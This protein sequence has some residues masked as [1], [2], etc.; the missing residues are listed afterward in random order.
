MPPFFVLKKISDEE[1]PEFMRKYKE[2]TG[3]KTVKGTKKLC[4]VMEV[5][6]YLV[7]APLLKWYLEHGLEVTA[8]H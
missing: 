1:I 4:G 8:A 7:Y 3:R 2:E 6:N 5:E